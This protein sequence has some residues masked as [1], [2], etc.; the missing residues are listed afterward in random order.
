MDMQKFIEG[1]EKLLCDCGA[2]LSATPELTLGRPTVEEFIGSGAEL[3][4]FC[5]TRERQPIEIKIVA[6]AAMIGNWHRNS[7]DDKQLHPNLN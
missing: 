1:L 6:K 2:E 4:V 3:G 5:V 7:R